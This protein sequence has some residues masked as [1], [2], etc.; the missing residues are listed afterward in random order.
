MGTTILV[1]PAA[2]KGSFGPRAVA[3]AIARGARRACPQATVLECP[4]ADG[5][6]GLLEAVLGSGSLRER[7]RVTG[8]L[9]NPV[10]AELGWV[11]PETAIFASASACGLALVPEDRRDPL[12][13]TTRGVGELLV[14]AADRGATTIVV[15]LGGS[16]TVDGGTGAARG[17]GW[18]FRDAGGRELPDGGGAL[19]ELA[20]ADGGWGLSARVVAL[21]DVRTRLTEAAAVFGPQKGAT[22]AQ[23]TQLAAGLTRLA[24]LMARYGRADLAAQPGSGAAGGLG[25]GLAY[26]AAADLVPGA[27]WVF[28]RIGFDAALAKADLVITGEGVF[29]ET[30]LLGKAPGEVVRRAQTARKKLAIVAGRA[31]PLIGVHM[32]TGEGATLDAGGIA[33]LGERAAR[34]AF[35]LPP[36]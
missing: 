33:A 26:F 12:R 30:S 29:D 27:A 23:V 6:D 1:A 22:E 9:G 14:E 8:P 28:D 24:D 7:V 21:A 16:A 5:G 11:D 36:A 17:V 31:G 2:Y 32:L 20:H 13:T 34:E 10:D 35:G 25:A 4:V 15:G 3:E 18:T 19:A